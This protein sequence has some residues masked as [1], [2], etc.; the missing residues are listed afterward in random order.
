MVHRLPESAR[1]ASAPL[2]CIRD[3]TIDK[4]IKLTR[5]KRLIKNARFSSNSCELKMYEFISLEILSLT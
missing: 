3:R 2:L 5:E 4:R 1:P